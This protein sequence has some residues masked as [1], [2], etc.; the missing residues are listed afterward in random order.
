[1]PVVEAISE[2]AHVDAAP[3]EAI[4]LILEERHIDIECTDTRNESPFHIESYYHERDADD[5]RYQ[6]MWLDFERRVQTETRFF[7]TGTKDTLDTL[8]AELMSFSTYGSAQLIASAGPNT[9]IPAL[10]RA[11]TFQSEDCL[12]EALKRPDLHLGPP[13][14]NRARA[15]RLN[16]SG[17]AVFYGATEPSVAMSEIR[18]PVGI[19]VLMGRFTLLRTIRLL[20]IGALDAIFHRGSSFDP[21]TI[22]QQKKATFLRTLNTR[23]TRAVLPDDEAKEYLIT[24]LIAEYLADRTD[25]KLDGVLY[26]S[27]QV[28]KVRANVMLFHRASRVSRLS[29]PIGTHICADLVRSTS[30]GWEVDYHVH[31][32]TPKTEPTDRE[33]TTDPCHEAQQGTIYHDT[34]EITLDLDMGNL[35]VHHVERVTFCARQYPVLRSC[36]SLDEESIF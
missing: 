36:S 33:S 26:R 25:L 21:K 18:P 31:E 20:D 6:G 3:A 15:G 22:E 30:D 2:A 8:F 16:P 9:L 12:S 13:P 5:S 27:A 24:Q 14:S 7:D 1:M 11:R 29:I 28:D 10:Y 4:R 35:S 32:T 34:R 17:I 23:L 19:R